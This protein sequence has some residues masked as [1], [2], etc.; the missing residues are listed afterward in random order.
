MRFA[1]NDVLSRTHQLPFTLLE[2]LFQALPLLV[3][4]LGQ[5]KA[6][7]LLSALSF[8]PLPAAA[9]FTSLN[10]ALLHFDRRGTCEILFFFFYSYDEPQH[11]L[12][13]ASRPSGTG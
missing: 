9:F 7:P 6:M 1:W 10:L 13:A 2:K 8:S 12:K 5:I 4:G 11:P 3:T